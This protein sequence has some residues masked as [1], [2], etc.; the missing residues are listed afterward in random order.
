[1]KSSLNFFL[2]AHPLILSLFSSRFL[3]QVS[4]SRYLP[5]CASSPLVHSGVLHKPWHH[6]DIISRSVARFCCCW[7][8]LLPSWHYSLDFCET[9]V[10]L[11]VEVGVELRVVLSPF[12]FFILRCGLVKWVSCPGWAW[13]RL[14]ECGE[15]RHVLQPWLWDAISFNL[16]VLV[17]PSSLFLLHLTYLMMSPYGIGHEPMAPMLLCFS[18]MMKDVNV[19]GFFSKPKP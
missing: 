17:R 13:F 11:C 9:L 1:M 3:A 14:P 8:S 19:W 15:Y 16:P 10:F 7:S 2:K 12:L 4:S 6:F 5:V 18:F